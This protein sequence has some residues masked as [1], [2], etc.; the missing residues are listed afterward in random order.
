[1]KTPA[2]GL[3]KKKAEIQRNFDIPRYT[4]EPY[5]GMS[6]KHQ[7]PACGRKNKFTRYVDVTTGD[8][9]DQNVGRCDREI[10]CGH[11][12]KPSEHFSELKNH[13]VSKEQVKPEFVGANFYIPSVIDS[14]FVFDSLSDYQHNNLV[15][16][17]GTVFPKERVYAEAFKYFVG[18][19]PDWDGATVF[20]QI[21]NMGEV[22]TGKIM[23]YA[24]NG[25]RMKEPYDLINWAHNYYSDYNLVQCLFGEHLVTEFT[26]V[27][28]IVESEKTALICS[29][30]NPDKTWLA[31]GGINNIQISKFECL[32][33]KKLRF[34]P[35]NG[36]YNVWKEKIDLLD[37]NLFTGIEISDF[38]ENNAHKEGDD[39]GDVVL[40]GI[41]K[42]LQKS[43]KN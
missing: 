42:K 11:H 9:I 34:H 14:K 43:N 3:N 15:Q 6:T 25:K 31:T 30:N 36:A 18:I 27:V 37:P 40:D 21:S 26:E 8:Y 39:L 32:K 22:R 16:Y 5:R 17:L 7:C 2:K 10:Q 24:E 12:K 33:N 1:M 28:D 38:M 20:W 13:Y 23:M 19:T 4:L 41:I 29:I 35:D